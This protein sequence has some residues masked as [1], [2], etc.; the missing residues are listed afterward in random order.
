MK[1]NYKASNSEGNIVD[2]ESEA[3][4]KFDLSNILRD[5]NLNLLTAEEFEKKTLK[6][7]IKQLSM[8]GTVST[9][10]KIIFA[11]NLGSMLEAGL[12][13]SRALLTLS[14][15]SKNK[16]FKKVIESINDNIK[17]GN[18]LADS[19]GKYPKVFPS[20][21]VAMVEAGEQSGNLIES[22]EVVSTQMDK[23]NEL[24]KKIIGALIY[25]GVIMSAMLV[26]GVFML[27]FIV[28]TLSGTFKELD[29]DLPSST[30]FIISFSEAFK[31]H[32]MLFVAV[33]LGLISLFVFAFNSKKGRRVIDFTLLHLPLITPLVRQ[34]NSARTARTLSS[35]LKSGVSYV[36]ALE[37]TK[38]VVQ[39]SYFKGV[40]DKAL[41]QVA[42][43][44]PV[45]KVFE[46]NEKLYP[47]FVS[48]MIA[49]G[50]ETGELSDMLL[51]VASYYEEEVDRKTKN[52]STIVEPFLMI[53]VGAG[54]G[55]FAVS[56]ISPMYQLV[57][58]I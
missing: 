55:F 39:N 48:E 5:Q 47:I 26:I 34:T 50:E 35:L 30:Q 51:R 15:Q 58:N 25:P 53:V 14:R 8:L 3:K 1:F 54:V 45:S 22:L 44:Q 11:R 32:Y 19:L 6:K 23:T 10:E 4:D 28:P 52:M 16:K 33:F 20:I 7:F 40:I 27:I 18:S 41:E 24:K 12:P 13:L 46:E 49:V 36:K 38:K 2:G 56:M 21:F 17:K 57:D 42:I 37:I 29:V 43:G 31:N 9:Q